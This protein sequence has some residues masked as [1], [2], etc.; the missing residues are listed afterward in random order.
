MLA[1]ILSSPRAT[2]T[3]IAIVETFTKIRELAKTV[4][5]LSRTTEKPA[6]KMLAQKGGEII[7][8]ILGDGFAASATETTFEID[9]ALT[10]FKHTVKRNK[11]DP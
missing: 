8:E 4:G 1:T 2:A 6:Q 7:A 3:T 9:L 11:A 5:E 10:K